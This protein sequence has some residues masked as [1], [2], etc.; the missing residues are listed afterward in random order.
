MKWYS[1][2]ISSIVKTKKAEWFPVQPLNIMDRFNL[3]E[4]FV[5]EK[6][7]RFAT[8]FSVNSPGISRL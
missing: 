2:N 1:I 4:T 5:V 3:S 7:N 6:F 8:V